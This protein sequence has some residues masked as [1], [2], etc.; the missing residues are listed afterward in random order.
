MEDQANDSSTLSTINISENDSLDS[1]S[2]V[3]LSPSP[4]PRYYRLMNSAK[5]QNCCM[6]LEN[7]Y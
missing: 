6:L 5:I 2:Y 7:D 4:V 1:L 3:S